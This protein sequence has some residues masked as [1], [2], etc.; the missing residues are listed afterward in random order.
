[1]SLTSNKAVVLL[2]GGLDS[3]VLLRQLLHEQFV[4]EALSVNYGQRHAVELQA[5]QDIAAYY[6]VPHT[7]L[8]LSVLSPLCMGGSSQTSGEVPVPLGHYADP[9]MKTTVVPNRNMILLALAIGRAI[10][11]GAQHVAYA[12]HA[13]DHAV[14]PDCRPAFANAM[15]DAARLCHYTPVMIIRPFIDKSKAGIVWLGHSLGA[16]LHLTYSCYQGVKGQHC[17]KCGTC[18]ERK[19]AFQLSGVDDPTV[20]IV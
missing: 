16:P 5:A 15:V 19:E 20:Y 13:G 6:R 9:S 4:C 10:T 1:M 12:A 7:I 3:C 17:G 18:V 2:S 11:I 14:Y 8:D